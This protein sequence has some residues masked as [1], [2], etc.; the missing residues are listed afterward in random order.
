MNTPQ[1]TAGGT[2]PGVPGAAVQPETHASL[3]MLARAPTATSAVR[4]TAPPPAA[5]AR[6]R[7]AAGTLVL[8]SH[9]QITRL[10]QAGQVGL[11]ALTAAVAIAASVLIP[12]RHAIESLGEDIA[13]TQ[14]HSHGGATPQSS[15]AHFVSTLPTR[16]QIPAV[17]GQV[18]QQAKQA[19]VALDSGHY[20]YSA[21]KSGGIARYELE[22]PVK[23][24]YPN[25]R[26]FINRTLATVPAAGLDKL[27]VERK[28]V[29]DSRVNADIRFVIFVRGE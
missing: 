18:F 29:G 24:D 5:L 21:A 3:T 12:A 14:Q 23:A 11:A 10:G 17:L 6:V 15:V 28:S 26:T 27:H 16:A 2:T 22:F 19:G 8:Q 4:S 7:A 9:Y 1:H 13:R 25:I 20:A